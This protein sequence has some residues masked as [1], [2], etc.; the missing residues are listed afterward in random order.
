MRYHIWTK[1][2]RVVIMWGFV[3]LM[4][5]LMIRSNC[6]HPPRF[7]CYVLNVVEYIKAKKYREVDRRS[8]GGGSH[9]AF[10]CGHMDVYIYI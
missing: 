7:S 10:R 8:K 6:Q 2:R 3:P 1:G 9:N 5:L 4:E